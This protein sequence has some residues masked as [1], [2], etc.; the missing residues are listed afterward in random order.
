MDYIVDN[1][2]SL[3][4]IGVTN[5]IVENISNILVCRKKRLS[6]CKDRLQLIYE[7]LQSPTPQIASQVQDSE[8]IFKKFFLEDMY[9][10]GVRYI[11][12]LEEWINK[13]CQSDASPWYQF[14]VFQV[15]KKVRFPALIKIKILVQT[16]R[17]INEVLSWITVKYKGKMEGMDY[18][19]KWLH[20]WYD[21]T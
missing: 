9:G 15:L 2:K 3:K 20:W 1:F 18:L 17:I 14:Q 21:F 7:Y 5:M 8:S 19:L 13:F 10:G 11:I 12:P 6:K 16:Q 4:I